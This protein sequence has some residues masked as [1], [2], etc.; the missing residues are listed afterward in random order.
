MSAQKKPH[1]GRGRPVADWPIVPTVR[2]NKYSSTKRLR[3]LLGIP[4]GSEALLTQKLLVLAAH[5]KIHCQ[6]YRAQG[7]V[8]LRLW[9]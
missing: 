2:A 7:K 6:E 8:I 9:Y 4:E 5:R 3:R 1:R